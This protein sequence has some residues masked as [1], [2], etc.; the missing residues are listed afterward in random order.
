MPGSLAHLTARF[1]DVLTARPLDLV[2]KTTVETWLSPQLHQLF[3]EQSAP[4]QRH[5]YEAALSVISQ[6][7]NDEDV[8]VAA[9]VHDVGKR[10]A[11]L[12]VVG[13]SVASLLILARLPLT[14]RM[15]TYRDHGII[16]AKELAD[17]GAPAVAI[18][19]A[20]HHHGERPHGFDARTWDALE[21]ADEP[22]N[23]KGE[24]GQGIS[25]V[26]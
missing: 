6:G 8:V 2:E 22:V 25:S 20:L 11:R 17:L 4:D 23:A 3:F 12:G 7:V 9:L 14:E 1:F 10:H 21:K 15:K 26:S 5:G 24:R 13:R 18:D 19:F 16:G